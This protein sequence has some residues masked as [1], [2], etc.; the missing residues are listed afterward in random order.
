MS[1]NGSVLLF[2]VKRVL[3]RRSG[4]DLSAAKSASGPETAP[5]GRSPEELGSRRHIYVFV[6]FL[7]AQTQLQAG[8]VTFDT[9]A[10]GERE[11]CEGF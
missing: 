7:S 8:N 1:Q 4:S 10:G 11:N 2:N 5:F 9:Q 3:S 6:C